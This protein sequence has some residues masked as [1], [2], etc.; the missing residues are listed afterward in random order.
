M[1][2]DGRS[3]SRDA[4]E[5]YRFRA[6]ELREKGWKVK[7]IAEAFGLNYGSVSHWFTKANRNGKNSLKSR[8]A[9]GK[10]PKISINERIQIL[11]WA[12]EDAR[13]F[14]FP[15]PLWTCK[16]IKIVI[17][18]KFGKSISISN[19]WELLRKANLTPKKPK[20]EAIEKDEKSVK[21]WIKEEWPVIKKI[22]RRRQAMLY[23]QDEA[24]VSLIPYL[25]TTW[26]PKGE[27]PVVKVTGKKGGVSVS[28]AI[29]PAGRM[30]FR[31]EK[32]RMTSETY[33]DFLAKI[34]LQHPRRKIVVVSDN[35]PIHKSKAVKSFI[36]SNYNRITLF[37]ISSYSPELNPDEHVWSYLKAY[38]LVAHQAQNKKE[39][40]KVVDYKMRKIARKEALIQSFF[41]KKYMH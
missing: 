1:K 15:N 6:L 39:L 4:L 14:G 31:I 34:I 38:E 8:K 36:L 29:S 35:A 18:R 3:I 12:K 16:Q 26:S 9:K 28:S 23:F 5:Q 2:K 37:H 20:K 30:I 32:G 10:E 21:R 24:G 19:V 13:T 17:K 25:R 40:R 27:T 11:E 41:M 33:I 7:K 22:V